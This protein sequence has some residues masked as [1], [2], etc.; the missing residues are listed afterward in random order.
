MLMSE[1][2]KCKFEGSAHWSMY[3]SKLKGGGVT[4]VNKLTLCFWHL[5][6][7]S[8]VVAGGM[9]WESGGVTVCVCVRP[10]RTVCEC[11]VR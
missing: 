1:V 11:A 8:R 6:I 4:D 3:P 5:T 9:C 10:N 7:V 2:C